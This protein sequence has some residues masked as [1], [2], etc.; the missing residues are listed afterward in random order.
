M[1]KFIARRLVVAILVGLCVSIISFSL[2]RISGDLASELAGEDATA[3]EVERIRKDLGLDR[4][5]MVQ[6]SEWLGMVFK[7]NL[8]KSMYFPDSV[9]VLVKKSYPKTVTLALLGLAIAVLI[10]I[11][12]GVFAALKPGTSVD[13]TA[14]GVAIMGQAMPTFWFALLLMFIFGLYLRWFPISGDKTIL[15]FILPAFALGLHAS[16][17]IIR[18]T[19]TGMLEV[20][21]SDYIRTAKAKGLPT[22]IILFK[23]ALRNA[24][25]PV[26][27]VLVVQFGILL[28]GSVVIETVFRIKGIGMLA[29]LSIS[30]NDFPVVQSIVLFVSC[31]YIVL[32]LI[33]DFINAW[34]DPRLRI[35]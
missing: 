31:V 6:Y 16:P 22:F 14:Q 9:L 19:R 17:A 2:L 24:L 23:H 8:G 3:E 4:P 32:V 21:D 20:M 25:I 18:L 35:K 15:H 33:G 5:F 30:R 12:M 1:L 11:P 29:W 10:S 13:R 27:G 7:G 34:L 28:N 26:V